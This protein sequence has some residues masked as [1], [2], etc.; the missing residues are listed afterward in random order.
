M[1]F[2]QNAEWVS[3][4]WEKTSPADG[5]FRPVVLD[6]KDKE[7]FPCLKNVHAV[8]FWEGTVDDH[9]Y[10]FYNL[11]GSKGHL[12]ALMDAMNS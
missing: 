3:Y 7:R 11:A 10:V 8:L 6:E 12:S 5:K 2:I 4:L 1:N 9:T